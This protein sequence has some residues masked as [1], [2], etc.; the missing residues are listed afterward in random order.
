MKVPA[1]FRWGIIA[2]VASLYSITAIS[3]TDSLSKAVLHIYRADDNLWG[4][5]HIEVNNV[6]QTKLKK[7][8]VHT[9][10]VDPGMVDVEARTFGFSS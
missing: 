7:L 3:Q 6:E 5:Y 4:K 1:I 2:L 9:M 10:E 8:N